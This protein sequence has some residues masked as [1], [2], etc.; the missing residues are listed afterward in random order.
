[1]TTHAVNQKAGVV[2]SYRHLAPVIDTDQYMGW[3]RS[4]ILSK[5]GHLVT[6][7]ITGDL[8]EQEDRLLAKYG[9]VAV[10]NC[11]GLDAY[12][13]AHDKTVVPLRGALIRVVNDGKRFPKVEEA[14][15]VSH[16]D[17]HGAEADD[18]VFIVPRNDQTLILGGMLPSIISIPC[19]TYLSW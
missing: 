15:A 9:A 6:G 17:T 8:L 18:I 2:D 16:D 12:E 19:L 7:H 5:G 14:L 4:L 11:T 10:I 1:M 3:L 13:T